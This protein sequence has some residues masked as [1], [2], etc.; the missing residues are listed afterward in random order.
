[1][2]QASKQTRAKTRGNYPAAEQLLAT[3]EIGLAQG[4][5]AGLEAEARNFGQLVLS[6]ESQALRSF[7]STPVRRTKKRKLTKGPNPSRCDV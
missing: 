2:A 7:H 5:S 6:A 3:V 4:T 1:M